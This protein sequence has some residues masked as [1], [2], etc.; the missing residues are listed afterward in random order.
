MLFHYPTC[1]RNYKEGCRALNGTEVEDVVLRG[2]VGA[3]PFALLT[4]I[5]HK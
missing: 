5:Y 4:L 1:W 2:K 3:V